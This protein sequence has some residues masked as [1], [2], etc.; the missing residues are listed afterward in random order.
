[1]LYQVWEEGYNYLFVGLVLWAGSMV[2]MEIGGG[3][4]GCLRHTKFQP[5]VFWSTMKAC[6]TSVRCYVSSTVEWA[7]LEAHAGLTLCVRINTC[8]SETAKEGISRSLYD[9]HLTTISHTISS[10]LKLMPEDV[11]L[12][13][14]SNLCGWILCL[15]IIQAVSVTMISPPRKWLPRTERF[16]S[17]SVMVSSYQTP[18]TLLSWRCRNTIRT[19]HPQDFS[20]SRIILK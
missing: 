17:S 8:N 5:W 3:L 20:W 14:W 9:Y 13:H 19:G 4:Y 1:M 12:K 6:P 7:A 15:C 10:V 18:V 11:I 2:A 16:L